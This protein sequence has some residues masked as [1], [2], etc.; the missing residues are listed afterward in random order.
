MH[1]YRQA[2]V[3][4]LVPQHVSSSLTVEFANWRRK[5]R[6]TW[7]IATST[8]CLVA[9]MVGQANA[10]EVVLQASFEF[11]GATPPE[12]SPPWLTAR[13]DDGG[14]TGLVTITL[15]ATNLTDNEYVGAWLLN[16]APPLDASD[17]IFSNLAK[18]GS[19]ADPIISL[20]ENQFKAD[21]DGYFDI[22]IAFAAFDGLTTR[23]TAGDS[24]SYTVTAPSL[25]AESFNCLSAPGGGV[26][27]FPMASHVQ[28]IG[29]EDD[30]S[31]WV[32][33]PEPSY[34]A[35]LILGGLA[36]MRRRGR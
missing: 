19:F 31:G 22:L 29:Q 15:E 36:V 5:M 17:L 1:G 2:A 28:G 11:S 9:G 26:G 33:T 8:L 18:V 35:V 3:A 7:I 6:N 30:K 32:T 10:A 24:V 21:G 16:V 13:F 34:F 12:G 4:S 23:F 20:G 27:P 25:T 14:G